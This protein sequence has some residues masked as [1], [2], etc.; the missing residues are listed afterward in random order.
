MKRIV[1]AGAATAGLSAARELRKA[2]F[3]GQ[4][5]LVDVEPESPYRRPEVSKGILDGRIDEETIRVRWPDDLGLER[6]LGTRLRG[7]DL[8]ARTV[9]GDHDGDPVTLPFDGL[10]LATGSVARPSPFDPNLSNVY[11]LRSLADGLRLRAALP[12]ARQLVL[13]GGGFIGLEVAAVARKLGLEVTVVEAADVPLGHAL[14]AAFGEHMADLHRGHGVR[15]ICGQS[16]SRVDSTGGVAESVT[17][18]DGRRLA[19][20]LVVVS[21]GSAPAVDW[22][23]S[24]GLAEVRC[25]ATCAVEGV[26]GVVAAGDLA[27]WF[28]PLYGRQMRVEH[29]TNAI[30]QGSYAARRLLGTHDPAGFVSAPYFWSD[31]Y[32]LRLQSIGSTSGYDEVEVITRDGPKMLVA[33]GRQGR[34][35]CVAGLHA[36]TAVMSYRGLVT[37]AASMDAVRSRATAVAA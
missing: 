21:I 10:V 35:I 13:V 12:G 8:A 4:L 36:G 1:I 23:A 17:L 32:G 37:E 2:G 14:G 15:I 9:F 25:D 27:S 30:E 16:V 28:N 34:V 31:Q 5:Q 19:A 26:D 7:V 22:L 3:D 33:Y 20:D 6:H 29:W 11:S 24:S 18:A